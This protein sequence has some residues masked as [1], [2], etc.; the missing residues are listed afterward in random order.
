MVFASKNRHSWTQY[1]YAYS[2]GKPYKMWIRGLDKI[3]ELE[4]GFNA[5]NE[6]GNLE[7]VF[8]TFEDA[9][10]KLDTIREDKLNTPA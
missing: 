10:S 6:D 8:N 3:Y 7:D 4:T 2:D 5:A 9:E 1:R